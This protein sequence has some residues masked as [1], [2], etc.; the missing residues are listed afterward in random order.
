M[1]RSLDD[2]ISERQVGSP[3]TAISWSITDLQCSPARL[4]A[5]EVPATTTIHAMVSERPQHPTDNGAASRGRGRDTR[6]VDSYVPGDDRFDDALDRIS[7]AIADSRRRAAPEGSAKIRV[8]NLHYELD[9]TDIKEL[10][11][12][13]GDVASC[14]L[15]YD[16]QDRSRGTAYVTYFDERDARDAMREFDGANAYGQP[17]R[18][19]L[20]PV[21]PA[22]RGGRAGRSLFDRIEDSHGRQRSASPNSLDRRSAKPAQEHIDRYMPGEGRRRSPGP[23]R[24]GGGRRA[25]ARREESGRGGRARDTEGRPAGGGRPK[26]T[27]EELD[28]EM[29]DYWGPGG[30]AKTAD[31]NGAAVAA[32]A[33]AQATPQVDGDID[34]IELDSWWSRHMVRH[35]NSSSDTTYL[36]WNTDRVVSL[37][38]SI[39]LNIKQILNKSAAVAMSGSGLEEAILFRKEGRAAIITLNVPKKLNAVSQAGFFRIAELLHEIAAMDDVVFTIVTGNGRFFTAGADVSTVGK[40][41]VEHENPR[42]YWNTQ[43][44][45]YNLHNTH[46]WYSHPKI[47][48][49]ALNGPAIGMGAALIAHADFVYAKRKLTL[50]AKAPHAYIATPFSSL[51]LVSEG[52]AAKAFVDKLGMSKATEAL[53]TSRKVPCD[54]LLRLG[55]INK[56]IRDGGGDPA[57]GKG[58]DNDKFMKAVMQ[59]IDDRLGDHLSHYAMLRMKALIKKPGRAMMDGVGIEEGLRHHRHVLCRASLD[60]HQ[61][62]EPPRPHTATRGCATLFLSLTAVAGHPA[63]SKDDPLRPTRRGIDPPDRVAAAHADDEPR[64]VAWAHFTS[65]SYGSNP[66]G[67]PPPPPPRN[68]NR[69]LSFYPGDD[70]PTRLAGPRAQGQPH[71]HDE[72]Q[73]PPPPPPPA[74]A[75]HSPNLGYNPQA[76]ANAASPPLQY[77]SQQAYSPPMRAYSTQ[78]PRPYNPAAY[79]N[80]QSPSAYGYVTAAAPM[81]PG[82][83]YTSYQ[84]SQYSPT[85]S[86]STVSGSSPQLQYTPYGSTLVPEPTYSAYRPHQPA[87]LPVPPTQYASSQNSPATYSYQGQSL[88]PD[89]HG[90]PP[91]PYGDSPSPN[92][93]ESQSPYFPPSTSAARYDTPQ[94]HDDPS[95]LAPRNDSIT[96]MSLP[97]T[98]EQPDPSGYGAPPSRIAAHPQAHPLPDCP[99]PDFEE[100]TNQPRSS[101]DPNEEIIAEHLAQQA[102]FEHVESVLNDVPTNRHSDNSHLGYGLDTPASYGGKENGYAEDDDYDSDA[103]AAAGLEAMRMAEEQEQADIRRHS[104]FNAPLPNP[105]AVSVPPTLL[106]RTTSLNTDLPTLGEQTTPLSP[107]CEDDYTNVDMGMYGGGF[108]GNLHYGGDPSHLISASTDVSDFQRNFPSTSSRATGA[109]DSSTVPSRDTSLTNASTYGHANARVE[110]A[111]GGLSDPSAYNRKLSFDEG[112]EDPYLDDGTTPEDSTLGYGDTYAGLQSRPLPPPPSDSVESYYPSDSSQNVPYPT[113]P[114]DL[115][116]ET[117]MYLGSAQFPRS[118]SFQSHSS[119]PTTVPVARRAKTDAEERKR[120]TMIRM[121]LY[122]NEGGYEGTLPSEAAANLGLDLPSLPAG[123]RFYPS[124]LT[125]RDFDRCTEPWALSSVGSWLRSMAGGE[126][127]LREHAVQEALVNLFTSKVSNLNIADAEALSNLVIKEMYKADMLVQEEEWLKF[128]LG[129]LAGVLFQL[130]GRGCYSRAVHEHDTPG[131]CYSHHCQRTVKKLTIMDPS[132]RQPDW[133]TFYHM[134]K[135]S[136]E[137]VNKKSIELQNI[138]HEIVTSE[139]GYMGELNVLGMLYR[140]GLR[141]AE[142]SIIPPKRLRQFLDDVFGKLGVV[143]KAN[144]DFLLPQLRY[145]QREQGPWVRGFSDIF[146]SW[147][148]KARS[149]YV[150]YAANFPH[151]SFLM[152]QEQKQNMLFNSFCDGARNNKLSGRLEWYSFLKAPITRLQ[153]YSLLLATAHKNMI[154]DSEEKQNLETAIEEIKAVTLECDARVADGERKTSLSD[155]ATKLKLRPEMKRVELNLTQWGRE[156]FYQGELQRTGT[157]RF[158]WLETHVLLFDNYMVLAKKV[159]QR[160]APHLDK[161]ERFDVSKMPIPMDLLVLESSDDDPVVKSSVKGI[162]STAPS[163][164]GGPASP[165]VTA[166]NGLNKTNSNTSALVTNLETGI[167]SRTNDE[168]TLYPFCVRHLGKDVYTLYSSTSQNRKVWC[169]KIIEAKTKH[170]ASLYAQSAEPFNLRVIADYSFA[171]DALGGGAKTV[172]IKGTPLS[173][174][175]EDVERTYAHTGR[176]API[177]RA[178]VNCSTTFTQPHGKQ[179]VVIGT[180]YGVYISESGNPRGWT[181]VVNAL[182]VTQVAVLEEFN[183]LLLISDKSLVAYHLDVVCPSSGPSASGTSSSTT[184]S[185]R[186]APQKLS[187]ARDVS[188]FAIGRLKDRALVFYKKRES[189]TSVFRVLEP[190]YQK[191]T[192]RRSRLHIHH[193]GHTD[194]FRDYDD[195]YVPADCSG[196]NIFSTSIAVASAKGFEV[197]NLDKKQPWSV[198]DLKQ[199]HVATIAARLAN[200]DTVAMFKLDDTSPLASAGTAG[201]AHPQNLHT[202]PH[203]R[204]N[205]GGIAAPSPTGA[206]EFLCVYEECAVYVNKHGDISRSVVLEFVGRAREAC[207]IGQYL[208]LF[209]QDFVEVRNALN[210]TLK[211]VVAGRDVRCLDNGRGGVDRGNMVLPGGLQRSIKFALQHPEHERSQLI[212]EMVL[213]DERLV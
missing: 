124:K 27:A 109:Y 120:Q 59:E 108:D 131:R 2:V 39:A 156:L 66:R 139:E 94:S 122:G 37:L 157:S 106:P 81:S 48:I 174:A 99:P 112:D 136:L 78:G 116:D 6:A 68:T 40:D 70:A 129:E 30:G 67:P 16:R 179:M 5:V 163:R 140:D 142:P 47:L 132:I 89:V 155:L 153:R 15:L 83:Q 125:Q 4:V 144:E 149:A 28:A 100:A 172:M 161:Y 194:S 182:R 10:F 200:M 92:M 3:V 180:D 191:A 52:G 190:V 138:L 23:R 207:L 107:G 162:S 12:R 86:A 151:A 80:A 206:G 133:M 72:P 183:L 104:V 26:K 154:S 197:L 166:T 146:R 14:E 165:G 95:F 8:D 192:E 203:S 21:G 145:R 127:E 143:Q 210:G 19:S 53:L 11:R 36:K 137:G 33:E 63:T 205:S 85:P 202:L 185:L 29:A 56:V 17:I 102:L 121:S 181:R 69:P 148:R 50:K 58:I 87:P 164:Q 209:D 171:Y 9:A 198:P 65:M 105:S 147:I 82:P 57:S 196:M 103:E 119:T 204:N 18:L 25:G 195:F 212:V 135:E 98:P 123:K 91:D 84:P 187:G 97:S 213:S 71:A 201:S 62:S 75:Q 178:R 93:H 20:V 51:G 173:R 199:P 7:S 188:F 60:H 96:S 54:E 73:L 115:L 43:L 150:D 114:S 101:R 79:Q 128:G 76:Y 168:K 211:Q 74:P 176:Q 22:T 177:C 208:V 13:I 117:G 186:R 49:V 111:I 32:P 189:L 41:P 64:E 77:A 55:F 167:S 175:I 113:D 34:M 61:A 141:T 44:V 1:D 35:L 130:T 24:G 158:T 38:L 159:Q 88:S 110:D 90:Q 193:R 160:D 134:S 118:A 126:T 184:D 46:A 152:K 45:S 170:A 42:K 31:A 169:E